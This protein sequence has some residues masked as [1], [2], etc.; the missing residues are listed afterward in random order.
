M[1]YAQPASELETARP[2]T[3]GAYLAGLRMYML[4]LAIWGSKPFEPP[5]QNEETRETKPEH[6][7]HF[8]WQFS[9]DYCHRAQKFA[10]DA[11][12]ELPAKSVYEMVKKRDEEERDIWVDKIRNTESLTLGQIFREVYQRREERWVFDSTKRSG[13]AAPSGGSGASGSHDTTLNALNN[14]ITQ[15]RQ[16]NAALKTA[17]FTGGGGGGGKGRGGKGGGAGGK[18][19]GNKKRQQ[20]HPVTVRQTLNGVALCEA[21]NKGQCSETCKQSPPEAHRCN[22]AVGNRGDVACN[23]NHRS[24]DCQ[25]CQRA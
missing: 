7:V 8:P 23:G 16:N 24:K 3:V 9:L 1:Q 20:G 10:S 19:G 2:H 21:W 14:T 18:G 6:Y 25:R 17:S 22:G 13:A 15:L 4:A 12:E 5:P 11:L